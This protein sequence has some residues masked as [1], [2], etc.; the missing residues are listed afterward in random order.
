MKKLPEKE[1]K[2]VVKNTPLISIDL[3]I[4]DVEGKILVGYRSNSPAKNTWFVPGGVIRK[5]ELF[6]NAFQRIAKDEIAENLELSQAQYIGLYEHIY[7]SNFANDPSFNTHYIVNAFS[8]Q[9]SIKASELKLPKDQHTRY[10]W[11]SP[12]ELLANEE[13]HPNTKNYF[14]GFVSF[15]QNK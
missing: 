5:N 11:A 1:Y 15:S 7:E 9:L 3:I 8:V 6:A 2:A 4:K 10:W 14:N 13:V 12:D